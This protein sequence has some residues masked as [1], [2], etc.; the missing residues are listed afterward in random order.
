VLS[1]AR[2]GGWSA[3]CGVAMAMFHASAC[4]APTPPDTVVV[5]SGP[6]TLEY[7][8]AL[9]GQYELGHKAAL[10]RA[11]AARARIGDANRL[12]NPRLIASEDN[13]GGS[14][15]GR[16]REG[17]LALGQ[18]FELGGDRSAR[19]LAA[20]AE[21]RLALAEAGVLGREGW[22][23]AAERFIAAWSL[24]ARLVRLREGQRLTEQAIA[25]AR[26]RFRAGASPELEV[27]RVQSRA[28][29]E[30]VERQRTNSELNLAR[31]E[32]AAG[33]GATVVTFDSLV[34]PEF[35]L[36]VG[37]SAGDLLTHPELGRATALEAVSG[38]RVEAVSAA[39]TPDLT[40]LAGVR[41][42]EE[43]SGTGFVVG[44]ELPLPLWNRANG[45]IAA[46][47]LELSASAAD[48]RAIEQQLQVALAAATERVRVAAAALDTLR[49]RVH[50]ARAE[51]V[52]G[53]LRAYR[54]GRASY[55]DLAAEQNNLLDT[56]LALIEAQANFWRAQMRLNQ[57]TG[58][59]P[60]APKEER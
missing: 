56:E 14:L 20:E 36:V 43:V 10:L 13:F 34:T 25:A 21:S 32:I 41:R 3:I 50:P 6:L 44:V 38:A 55:L 37:A 8:L 28:M 45:S 1:I 7:A 27:L 22:G 12:S 54:E 15:G 57:L 23:R 58:G 40:V 11:E 47:E 35:P 9:A 30:A 16:H 51:L 52:T 46:A 33:W 60:L 2:A 49:L 29:S 17:T 5:V 48:R 18:L 19:K 59:G 24:Q 31:L 53:M 26:D 39:R 42:L 4:A